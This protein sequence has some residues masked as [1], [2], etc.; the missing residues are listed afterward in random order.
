MRIPMEDV[1][2]TNGAYTEKPCKHNGSKNK[3]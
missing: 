1:V 3:T 2:Y